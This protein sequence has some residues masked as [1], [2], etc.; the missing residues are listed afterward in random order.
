MG[1]EGSPFVSHG[2][3]SRTERAELSAETRSQLLDACQSAY[4]EEACGVLAGDLPGPAANQADGVVRVTAVYPIRN[5]ASDTAAAFSF[6]PQDWINTLYRIQKNRQ[7]L[8]GI[9]HSHPVQPAFPSEADHQ[10][11]QFGSAASY[12][13]ISLADRACPVIQPYRWENRAFHPL[14][15]A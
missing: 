1:I 9:Y 10:G 2:C 6:H 13:I 12:W 4:P 11:M 5:T 3:S 14:V 15:L 7:S 8:V